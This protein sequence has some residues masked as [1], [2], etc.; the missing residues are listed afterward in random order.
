MGIEAGASVGNNVAVGTAVGG[1]VAAGVVSIAISGVV[2]GVKGLVTDIVGCSATSVAFSE[3]S[4]AF[5]VAK[6]ITVG[7]K[8][9]SGSEAVRQA[10]RLRQRR[11]R[12]KRMAGS[13][14]SLTSLV[15]FRLGKG[16]GSSF[17]FHLM[18]TTQGDKSVYILL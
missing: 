5:S 11:A 18:G 12:I 13:S 15:D 17:V 9:G 1:T 14:D 10:V 7:P 16:M 2:V 4:A 6:A 8:S 3:A